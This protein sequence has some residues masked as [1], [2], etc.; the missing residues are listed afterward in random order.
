[1]NLLKVYKS[2]IFFALVLLLGLLLLLF[3]EGDVDLIVLLDDRNIGDL[4]LKT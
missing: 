3:L 1:M 2:L 4:R